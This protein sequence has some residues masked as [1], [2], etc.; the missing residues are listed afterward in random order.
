MVEYKEKEFANGRMGEGMRA[1]GWKTKSMDMA[2]IHGL[3]VV[4]T[5]VNT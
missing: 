4:D 5:R 3:M 2:F 1:L